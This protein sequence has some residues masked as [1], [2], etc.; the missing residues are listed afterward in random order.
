M[1]KF[2]I[3]FGDVNITLSG[4]KR[5]STQRISKGGEKL[6]NTIKELALTDIC[7]RSHPRTAEH[8]FFPNI[9]GTFTKINRILVHEIN[10]N[11]FKE[12]KSFKQYI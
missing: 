11:T 8:A 5:T 9:Q 4:T 3:I 7:R 12:L 6:N 2:I 10:L 1:N